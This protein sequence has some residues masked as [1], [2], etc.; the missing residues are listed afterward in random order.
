MPSYKIVDDSVVARTAAATT[1]WT[2]FTTLQDIFNVAR[3]QGYVLFFQPG[4]YA[5]GTTTVLTTDGGGRPLSVKALPGSVTFLFNGTNILLRVEGQSEVRFEGIIFN[6]QN[7]VLTDYVPQRRALIAV[8]SNARK[9]FFSDCEIINSPGI[10]LYVTSG[11]DVI[12]ERCTFT[13]HSVG[14]WSENA[15]IT[16]ASNTLQ[17]IANNAINIWRSTV[18]GDS[19]TVTGNIINGVQSAAGGTG[20]NGNGVAV[21]RAVGVTITDNKIFNCQFSAIRCNGGGGF[22]ISDNNIFN[23]REVAIF[24]EA[25]SPGIDLTG[26]IVANN[27]LDT[28]GLGISVA[29]SGQ[30]SDG[31]SRSVIVTGNRIS[32]VLKNAIPD[33]GYVP[34]VTIGIGINVEQ[35]C[36]VSGNLIEN[37]AGVGIQAGINTA[38]RDLVVTGNLVRSSPL[39]IGVSND[40]V[41]SANRSIVVSGNVVRTASAGGI[42][43]TLFTGTTI[44]RVGTIEYGNNLAT[45]AGSVTFGHNR[46][47]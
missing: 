28:V 32:N 24:I 39:G 2:A 19:S 20:E 36:V 7:R 40:A 13:S 27:V 30:F 16:A 42:V 4:S 17:T 18:T 35:D 44:S 1:G 10:G 26:A 46:F 33:P 38:A 5:A 8:A 34:P 6:G 43:P 11:A 9:V 12:I 14:I 25:P 23:T 47:V 15:R 45:T 22:N 3:T 21:F 41:N 31:V 37:A 29:N